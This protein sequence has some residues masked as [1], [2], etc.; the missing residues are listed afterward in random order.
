[1]AS[2]NINQFAAG[3]TVPPEKTMMEIRALLGKHGAQ[4]IQ[5][6]EDTHLVQIAFALKN[7]VIRFEIELPAEDGPAFRP[8]YRQRTTRRALWEAEIRRRWRVCLLIIKSKLEAVSTNAKLFDVEL[9]PYFVM[10][11]G[12][13][14][15]QHINSEKLDQLYEGKTQLLLGPA[16]P[17]E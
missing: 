14:V 1:M 9:L 8:S 17:S 7:R 12:R 11:D 16:N 15:A 4:R 6:I 13:T 10:P 3:T 5:T 2:K